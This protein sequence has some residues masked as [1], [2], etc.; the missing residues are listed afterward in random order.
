MFPQSYTPEL[1]KETIWNV[2]LILSVEVHVDKK[3]IN[4]LTRQDMRGHKGGK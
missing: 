4:D 2:H 3:Q 1:I